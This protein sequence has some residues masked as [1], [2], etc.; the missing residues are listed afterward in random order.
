[1]GQRRLLLWL[2]LLLRIPR[3]SM[4]CYNDEQ[5]QQDNNVDN[6]QNEKRPAGDA[7]I[8]WRTDQP[9]MSQRTEPM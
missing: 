7:F 5:H 2:L 6:N 1:M 4:I 8:A 9:N 3:T